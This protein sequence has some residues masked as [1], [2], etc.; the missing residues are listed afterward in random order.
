ML[1]KK[2]LLLEEVGFGRA[3]GLPRFMRDA[4]NH[5]IHS[6]EHIPQSERLSVHVFLEEIENSPLLRKQFMDMIIKELYQESELKACLTEV[7]NNRILCIDEERT[8][9]SKVP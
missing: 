5:A 4:L 7:I 3:R 2:W 6:W 8:Q 1:V 9:P